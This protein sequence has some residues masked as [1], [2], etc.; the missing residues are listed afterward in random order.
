MWTDES[1]PNPFVHVPVLWYILHIYGY[2]QTFCRVIRLDWN[3][4]NPSVWIV[5]CPKPTS[6]APS[7]ATLSHPRLWHMAGGSPEWHHRTMSKAADTRAILKV[8][9]FASPNWLQLLI[10]YHCD[11][12][13]TII[14]FHSLAF[15]IN[16]AS[17]EF[18]GLGVGVTCLP[19]A[20]S[21]GHRHKPEPHWGAPL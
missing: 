7:W 8:V 12:D 1:S 3:P 5:A 11:V 20:L 16:P 19:V 13:M 9:D 17:G 6:V 10:T 18:S 15:R 2:N 21:A 4:P 14:C